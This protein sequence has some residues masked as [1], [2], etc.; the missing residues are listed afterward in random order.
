MSAYNHLSENKTSGAALLHN[1]S[2][3]LFEMQAGGVMKRWAPSTYHH[4]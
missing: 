2:M 3:A 1:R 4:L